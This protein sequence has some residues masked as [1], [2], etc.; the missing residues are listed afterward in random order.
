MWSFQHLLALPCFQIA[1]KLKPNQTLVLK[2]QGY[3]KASKTKKECLKH[4][5]GYVQLFFLYRLYSYLIMLY[6]VLGICTKSHRMKQNSK[7]VPC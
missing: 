4:A 2:R 3:Y 1:V 7:R 5:W 6:F